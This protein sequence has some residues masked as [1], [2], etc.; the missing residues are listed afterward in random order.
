MFCKVWRQKT[1]WSAS[2]LLE[3]P[4]LSV[5]V[6]FKKNWAIFFTETPHEVSLLP[7]ILICLV[8]TKLQLIYCYQ[9]G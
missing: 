4:E 5:A 1:E 2:K 7:I 3:D 8:V 9:L 6:Q